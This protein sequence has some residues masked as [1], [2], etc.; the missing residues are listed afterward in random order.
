[1]RILLALAALGV[2]QDAEARYREALYHEV[3]KGD[4]EKAIE[5]YRA[6][7]SDTSGPESVRARAAFRG[8]WCLDKKGLRAEAQKGYRDVVERYS[9]HAEIAAKA[10]ERLASG[11]AESVRP[12][13]PEDRI[14]ELI[15]SLGS[16]EDSAKAYRSLILIG[17]PAVPALRKALTHKDGM[18][19]CRAASALV[20]LGQEEGTFP[21]LLREVGLRYGEGQQALYSLLNRRPELGKEFVEALKKEKEL[22]VLTNLVGFLKL[23]SIDLPEA[24]EFIRDQFLRAESLPLAESAIKV[25][26]PS[27]EDALELLKVLPKVAHGS[28]RAN[29]LMGVLGQFRPEI[30]DP[31]TVVRALF[32]VAPDLS[33][34]LLHNLLKFLPA[35]VVF[36]DLG[37]HW[38]KVGDEKQRDFLRGRILELSDKRF[39]V[40]AKL[41]AAELPEETRYLLL[42]DLGI[43]LKPRETQPTQSM[44]IMQ[45]YF[46][47]TE[48]KEGLEDAA[49]IEKALWFVFDREKGGFKD[50]AAEGLLNILPETHPRWRELVQVEIS[51][52]VPDEREWRLSLPRLADLKPACS[53]PWRFGGFSKDGKAYIRGLVYRQAT[54][55]DEQ[56]AQIAIRLIKSVGDGAR[57]EVL[58]GIALDEKSRTRKVRVAAAQ[59]MTME[60]LPGS[61]AGTPE[62]PPPALVR[63]VADKDPEIRREAVSAL[64][65]WRDAEVDRVVVPLVEDQDETVAGR[66][67]SYA[68]AAPSGQGRNIAALVKA[69][70]SRSVSVRRATAHAL[71]LAESLEAVPHL[72][73]LLDDQDPGVREHVRAALAQIKKRHEEKAQWL[74]WYERIKPK[75]K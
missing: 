46:G 70:K 17:E 31:R 60:A 57:F 24:R 47:S 25:L 63:L 11:A 23:Y 41:L 40:I 20:E 61:E 33:A 53:V 29:Y 32:P 69:L 12:L 27:E 43:P 59:A 22:G 54:E 19:R 74:E 10:R 1:M 64:C 28:A 16:I 73:P 50:L 6:L 15:L 65:L 44:S 42:T 4:L 26:N 18:L 52:R 34:Q 14:A 58:A 5:L 3:D 37:A 8:A 48:K 36:E 55:P 71:G 67:V 35:T 13:S 39:E 72:I 75:D 68:F 9:A 7:E 2:L 56:R 62:K 45:R 49:A 38:L 51:Q 21:V 30:K 66:A